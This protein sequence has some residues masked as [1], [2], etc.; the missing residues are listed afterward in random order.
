MRRLSAILALVVAVLIGPLPAAAQDA[1]TLVA[2]RLEIAGNDRLV[3]AGA[4]EV[5][6]RGRSLRAA[7]LVYDRGA[8]RLTIEGPILLDDGAG[9][10]ILADQAELSADLQDGILRSARLVLDQQLQLA[11]AEI[12]RIGGR[13]TRLGPTVAS[14]CRI[15]AGGRPPLWEVRARR[16][17]HDEAE[18]QIYFDA[19][20]LRFGG[21]PVLFI[22][23]LRIPDPTLGRATGLLI[24][25]FRSSSELGTGL[26]LPYF[27]T[28]GA[29]RDLT[30]TP[31]L[32][33]KGG[34]TLE[35]RYRQ[36]FATGGIEIDGAVSRDRIRPGET[37]GYLFAE[38]AFRLP[39]GFR[40]DLR[41]A[42]V[43]DPA[44]L[45]DYG[46][47]DRDRL[48]S[49][50]EISRA[51]RDEWISGRLIGI[52]SIRAGEDDS[53]LP[54]VI[55]DLTWHRRFRPALIGG[56]GGLM[57][58]S[59]A[60]HRASDVD[61][62]A[63]GDG[64]VDGRD[65]ARASLRADWRRDWRFGPGIEAALLAE[66][67]ADFYS[68]AQDAAAGGE[69]ARLTGAAALE[70]RWP[71]LRTTAG[72]A[73]QVLEPVVQLV[74]APRD[75]EAVPNEDSTLA[76]FDE[77]SL[78]SLSRFPGNDG[79]ERGARANLGV[80]FTHV[81]PA[82]WTLGLAAGRVFRDLAA[83]EF[84]AA[85]GL[86][87]R[88]S[89]WLIAAQVT[90]LPGLQLTNRL[91]FD[92]AFDLTRGELRLDLAADR[93]ALSGSYVWT[94]ADAL[95]ERDA[96]V[97]ELVIDARYDFAGGRW[98]GSFSG[99]YDFVA[100]RAAR[101]GLNLGYRNE[102]LRVDLSLSR[103]FTS[104]TSVTPTT[105]VGLSVELLGFGGSARPGPARTCRG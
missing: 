60:H 78:F 22:P 67:G 90:A 95:E 49:R 17:V 83:G 13:Y 85:S 30:L 53:T 15:C 71:L 52:D 72:G 104:S 35:L 64:V 2:D 62:D 51:R 14:S 4:V 92:D 63:N 11:A 18:R 87:G 24:P 48:E 46:I 41:G 77:A 99:R 69:V 56:T 32:S 34:R 29:S 93:Y 102:C 101:A 86:D 57:F 33:S 96:D 44:Y 88:R 80:T 31:F 84:S 65:V 20:Q 103:R 61:F 100:E 76:E 105:D 39:R 75:I 73:T 89:D 66:A 37:R 50:I 9:T 6:F 3:A 5:F 26:K 7:R 27:I 12:M 23:R 38:G 91:V 68:I 19:A 36:A 45:L 1:A 94:E 82:G 70:L 25:E 28:L 43:S 74:W 40:L 21:V 58:Q 98:S 79:V 59:H 47:S 55:A 8:D 54:T 10:V 42:L 97:S 81:A 16:V